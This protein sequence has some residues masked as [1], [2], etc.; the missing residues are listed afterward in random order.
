MTKSPDTVLRAYRTWQLCRSMRRVANAML[1]F[2]GVC[3]RAEAA[4]THLWYAMEMASPAGKG[5]IFLPRPAAKPI[6]DAL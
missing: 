6:E 4:V 3:V 5:R 1:V 2:S